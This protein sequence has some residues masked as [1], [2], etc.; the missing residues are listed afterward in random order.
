M[1]GITKRGLCL[2]LQ[3][4]KNDRNWFHSWICFKPTKLHGKRYGTILSFHTTDCGSTYVLI[5]FSPFASLTVYTHPTMV[6]TIPNTHINQ[7][8]SIQHLHGLPSFHAICCSQSPRHMMNL[9]CVTYTILVFYNVIAV[10]YSTVAAIDIAYIVFLVIDITNTQCLSCRTH[11]QNSCHWYHIHRVSVMYNTYEK[12]L[13][14]KPTIPVLYRPSYKHSCC[15][16]YHT[17]TE[18]LPSIHPSNF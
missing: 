5:F 7:H 3:K 8:M 15:H 12:I 11:T 2:K 13:S 14:H 18:F 10:I 9:C 6:I 17:K 1:F 4:K 16:V